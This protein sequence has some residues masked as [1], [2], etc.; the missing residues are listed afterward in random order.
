[1]DWHNGNAYTDFTVLMALTKINE[2]T[3]ESASPAYSP[4]G[5]TRAFGG[6]AYAQAAY[7]AAHTVK[8]GFV[9]H[10]CTLI[11]SSIHEAISKK[12]KGSTTC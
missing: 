3:Y 1:M 9:L 8:K 12:E 11:D 7:A 6:H 4:G 5:F 2:K 10:V